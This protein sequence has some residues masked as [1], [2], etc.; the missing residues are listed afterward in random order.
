MI[1][2]AKWMLM[3]RSGPCSS[4][5]MAL[6]SQVMK[7]VV[8]SV[9]R[10]RPPYVDDVQHYKKLLAR[11]ARVEHIEV[12]EDESVERR[13]PERAFVSLLASDG[14]TYDSVAFSRWLQ[15]RRMAGRDVCFVVGGPAELHQSSDRRL[16]F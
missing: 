8:V 5:A 2:G 6:V 16:T 14:E 7:L 12:R 11:H 4:E 3:W 10:L 1:S 9:G 13:I 15:E